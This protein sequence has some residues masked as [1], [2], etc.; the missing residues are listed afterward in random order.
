MAKR[1]AQ[2]AADKLRDVHPVHRGG[3]AS[4]FAKLTSSQRDDLSSLRNRYHAGEYP[5]LSKTQVCEFIIDEFSLSVLPAS[6]LAWLRK[7]GN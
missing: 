7:A 3:T 4:W 1:K 6:V 5:G 2:S